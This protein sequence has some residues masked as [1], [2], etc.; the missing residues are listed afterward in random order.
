MSHQPKAEQFGPTLRDVPRSAY[1]I[2][3]DCRVIKITRMS[4]EHLQS[5]IA[6]L[7][8]ANCLTVAE[9]KQ[10][11]NSY[12]SIPNDLPDGAAMAV[13]HEADLFFRDVRFHDSLG[14][15]IAELERRLKYGNAVGKINMYWHKL[16]I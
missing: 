7:R 3:A 13:E 1:W 4:T 8:K 5:S 6:L 9:Y 12:L 10:R 16:S 14:P 11:L 2:T 15:M